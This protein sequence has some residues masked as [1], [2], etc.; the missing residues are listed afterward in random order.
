[1]QT[2]SEHPRKNPK[3]YLDEHKVKQDPLDYG[4]ADDL[5]DLETYKKKFEIV[6][7]R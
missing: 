5:F 4:L 1:M 7:I 2:D 3:L 6:I